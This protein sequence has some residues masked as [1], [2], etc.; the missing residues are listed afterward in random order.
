MIYKFFYKIYKTRQ[1][2]KNLARHYYI[3]WSY[4]YTSICITFK[5]KMG[6][7]I[8]VKIENYHAWKVKNYG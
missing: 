7:F 8:D 1:W 5:F 4:D 6:E 2:A 3:M